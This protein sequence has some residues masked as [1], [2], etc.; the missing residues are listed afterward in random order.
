M[1]DM[2]G[3]AVLSVHYEHGIFR[4]LDKLLFFTFK[5]VNYIW[6]TEKQ[7]FIKLKGLDEGVSSEVLHRSKPLTKSDQ[8]MR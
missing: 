5:K 2:D 6:D 1:P 7:E 4:E 3:Q 8:F